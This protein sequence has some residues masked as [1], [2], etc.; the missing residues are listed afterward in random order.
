[1]PLINYRTSSWLSQTAGI[2]RRGLSKES[3]C[4]SLAALAAIDFVAPL[5]TSIG[6]FEHV[7]TERTH[8]YGAVVSRSDS[9]RKA[10]AMRSVHKWPLATY[11]CFRK[12][13]SQSGLALSK[14]CKGP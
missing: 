12:S 10:A 7:G 11:T 14:A 3:P 8:M 1:M 9:G 4:S 5:Y 6:P 2:F 13:M